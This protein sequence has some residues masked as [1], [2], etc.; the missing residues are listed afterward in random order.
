M[1][2][3]IRP[4]TA[5]RIQ[6]KG[7][8]LDAQG[9]P[10]TIDTSG[11]PVLPAYI[12]IIDEDILV[13]WKNKFGSEAIEAAAN[14]AKE[15]ASLRLWYLPGVTAD[16]IITRLDDSAEFEIIGTPDDVMNR[17]QFLEIQVKRYTGG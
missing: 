16:C 8:A 4:N 15:P 9:N 5:V 1:F 14:Q 17:H 11:H 6:K 3:L 10:I 2:K 12:D 7:Y 13:E